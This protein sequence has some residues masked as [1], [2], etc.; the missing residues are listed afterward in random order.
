MSCHFRSCAC[1]NSASSLLVR[2]KSSNFKG[3]LA[4]NSISCSMNRYAM[5]TRLCPQSAAWR[6][7]SVSCERPLHWPQTSWA[8]AW[9]PCTGHL[10]SWAWRP[11]APPSWANLQSVCSRP[12]IYPTASTSP[13]SY[14]HPGRLKVSESQPQLLMGLN[15]AYLFRH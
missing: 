1:F 9:R 15:T 6:T 12:G 8:P 5:L 2:G 4:S 10:W 11:C 7:R 13:R 3:L 14:T